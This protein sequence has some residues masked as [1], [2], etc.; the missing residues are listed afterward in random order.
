MT[1][2]AVEEKK[3]VKEEAKPVEKPKAEAKPEPKPE[4]KEEKKEEKPKEEKA[5]KKEEKPVE[6]EEKKEKEVKA[7]EK[8]GEAE[9]EVRRVPRENTLVSSEKYLKAGVHI[10]TRF[11]TGEMKRFIYKERRD[12]LKV[13]NV[14]TLDERI[15]VAAKFL[16]NFELNR[17]I[18]VAR[19]LYGQTPAQLFADS[20]GARA[21]TGRFVPGSFTNP[22][23]KEFL[24]P[25]AIIVSETDADFQAIKEASTIKVPVVALASTNNSLKDVDLVIPVNNKGRKSIAMVYWLLAKELLKAKG[26]IKSDEEFKKTLEDFEF[27]LKEDKKDRPARRFDRRNQRGRDDRSRGRRRR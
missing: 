17:I 11:K 22:Q 12:G 23:G 7:A 19:K 4:K 8:E 20:I 18:V 3:E 5:V 14:Q 9:T 26:E 6:K 15:R 27:E 1:E 24:E 10:G 13:L 16:S 25:Q 21:L 2:K